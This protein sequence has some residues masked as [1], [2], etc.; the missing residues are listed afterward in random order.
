MSGVRESL[1]NRLG[2]RAVKGL[3]VVGVDGSPPSVEALS[4]AMRLAYERG[5]TVEVI[6]AWPDADA[7][8]VHEVPG[9][10]CEP[11]AMARLAQ[12]RAVQEASAAVEHLPRLRTEL[13]NDRPVDALVGASRHADLLVMGSYGRP[14]PGRHAQVRETCAARARCPVVVVQQD[15]EPDRVP[16]PRAAG[17][18]R[19]LSGVRAP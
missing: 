16:R 1:T 8:W 5:W 13:S 7:V 11:R 6:T 19:R 2:P 12:E 9:H 10:F 17:D 3:V 14:G 4:W 15:A 18:R